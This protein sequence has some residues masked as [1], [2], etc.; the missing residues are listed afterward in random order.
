MILLTPG[1]CMTSQAVRMAAALPDLNHREPEFA[2]VIRDVRSGL[3]SLASSQGAPMQPYLIGGSGTAAVEAMISSCIERGPALIL[4]NGYYSERL[5]AVF[6]VHNIPHETLRFGWLEPWDME[7]VAQRL[8]TKQFEA[9]LAVH[10]ETTTGRLNPVEGLAKL[11]ARYGARVLVDAVSS[12][13]GDPLDLRGVDAV[14]S[15]ANKCL[16]G[17]PG[18]SFVL[19]EPGFAKAIEAFPRRTYYLS[20]PMYE[21][22]NPPLTPPVPL[23]RALRQALAENAEQG[24]FAARHARYAQLAGRIRRTLAGKGYRFAVPEADASC[25]MTCATLPTGVCA[26]QWF[27]LNHENGFELYRCKG[28]L[29][30]RFF[31]VANMGELTDGMVDAWLAQ[32]PQA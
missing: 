28:E 2:E 21:G 30:E 17:L 23:L 26:E 19:L 5:D 1:P 4:A 18:V 32:V 6:R 10:H 14:C 20:L 9:V 12:L 25:T 29:A 8:K 3:Q 16:H 22:E 27:E 24:G 13:G 7:R 11:A 31:Q 15:S